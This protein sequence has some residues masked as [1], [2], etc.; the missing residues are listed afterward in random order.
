MAGVSKALDSDISANGPLYRGQQHTTKQCSII[1]T[2]NCSSNEKYLFNTS[3]T[4][5]Q[6]RLVDAF[7]CS[8]E[9]H[10]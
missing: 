9:I 8:R 3:T 1:F 6:G 2:K 4:L 7:M 5:V 10:Q